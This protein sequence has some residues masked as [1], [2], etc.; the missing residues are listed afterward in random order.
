MS[1]KPLTRH[2]VKYGFE[3]RGAVSADIAF[4]FGRGGGDPL[5]AGDHTAHSEAPTPVRRPSIV[6]G[7]VKRQSGFLN[8]IRRRKVDEYVCFIADFVFRPSSPGRFDPPLINKLF[9]KW[10][11]RKFPVQ[12]HLNRNRPKLLN[13]YCSAARS[14]NS[15][16]SHDQCAVPTIADPQSHQKR[17]LC[18]FSGNFKDGIVA[19]SA[20]AL[21][22]PS[23]SCR[24]ETSQRGDNC[25]EC[26]CPIIEPVT[27]DPWPEVFYHL[28]NLHSSGSKCNV[29]AVTP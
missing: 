15:N 6:N 22:E 10:S 14:D 29:R 9:G 1:A 21:V 18:G 13:S 17:P 20:N 27:R 16:L 12:R 7:N 8:V 2:G 26:D 5:D 25:P 23:C 24:V 19:S 4:Q 28:V 11:R 3:P